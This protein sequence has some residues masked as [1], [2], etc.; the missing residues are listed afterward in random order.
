M[1]HWMVTHLNYTEEDIRSILG[2]NIMR[3]FDEILTG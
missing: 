1:K 3:V 2:G